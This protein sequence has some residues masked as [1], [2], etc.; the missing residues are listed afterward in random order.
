MKMAIND[1]DSVR[2]R[3]RRNIP[4]AKNSKGLKFQKTVTINRPVPE[5]YGF[6]RHL[7]NLPKFMKH[8]K[9]VTTSGGNILHWAARAGDTTLEWDVETIEVRPNELISW[10]SLPAAEVTSSG[11]VSFRPAAGN[12]GTVVTVNLSYSPAGARAG[13]KAFKLFGK[14][15]RGQMEEDLYWLK[16]LLETGEIPTVEGQPHGSRK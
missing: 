7:D 2:S 12:R 15:T 3:T 9:A 6:C 4:A 11:S 8:L 16:S 10:Q 13:A 5:V 14:D 1:E